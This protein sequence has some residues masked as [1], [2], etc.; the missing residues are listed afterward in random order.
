[1]GIL[2]PPLGLLYIAACVEREGHR[3]SVKDLAVEKKGDPIDFRRGL[4]WDSGILG[5]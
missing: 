5:L 4:R 3:V 1:M 2:F